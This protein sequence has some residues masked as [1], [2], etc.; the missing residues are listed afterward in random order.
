MDTTVVPAR[1]RAGLAIALLAFAQFIVAVDYNIVY[2]AL[3]DI[4]RALGF[5]SQSLQWVVSA[6]AVA[7]GGFLLCAGR[8]VD[9]LG[10]RRAFVAG[11]VVFGLA[12]LV[13]GLATAPGVLVAARAVQ[14][15]GGALLTPATLALISTTF[16]EGP[17]RTRALSVWGAAGS[18]GLAAGALLGGVLTDALGWEWTLFVLVPLSLGAAVTAE[19]VLP[20]DRVGGVRQRF[21]VPGAVLATAGSV[22]LVFGLVTGPETGWVRGG[23]AVAG[24]VAV[25]GAFAAVERRTRDPLVPLRLFGNRALVRAIGVVLLFQSSLGGAYYLFTTHLQGALGYRPLAAGLAFVPLTLVSMTA[26]LKGTGAAIAR[27]GVRTTLVV[28]M[29]VNGVGIALLAGGMAWDGG[30]WL[31]L[32]GLVVWGVGGGLTFPAM[33]VAASS[34]VADAEQGVASALAT[35]SQQVGGSMGL[36]ALIALAGTGFGAPGALAVGGL[37]TVVGGVVLAL[38]PRHR[39]EAVMSSGTV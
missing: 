16:T 8:V 17:A 24:G 4:G 2:V 18:G 15:V 6:Y 13:G 39:A 32:P 5:S 27:W 21:D 11:L 23:L 14:G 36:A 37:A 22:L 10:A 25:L 20:A 19:S 9:R 26:S 30:F 1:A 31:L 29:V 33:F 35:T 38:V 7:F 12:C 34:G 28:G 3:P